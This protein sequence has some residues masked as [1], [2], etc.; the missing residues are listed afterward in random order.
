MGCNIDK[1]GQALLE[2]LERELSQTKRNQRAKID[3]EK[4]VHSRPDAGRVGVSSG[5][6]PVRRKR[7]YWT[8]AW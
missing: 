6:A 1:K 3:N 8:T 5:R 4:I 7:P 2:F